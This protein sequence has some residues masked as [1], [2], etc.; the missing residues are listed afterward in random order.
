MELPRGCL[1]WNNA[2]VKMMIDGTDATTHDF[3]GCCYGLRDKSLVT[4]TCISRSLG[5][6]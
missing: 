2:E 3:D 5:E 4:Q 1:Y 6:L